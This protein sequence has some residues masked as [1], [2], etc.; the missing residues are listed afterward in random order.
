MDNVSKFRLGT[1]VVLHSFS[2]P[3]LVN[4]KIFQN[5]VYFL[6]LEYWRHI[7]KKY[8]RSNISDGLGPLLAHGLQ[9]LHGAFQQLHLV[10]VRAEVDDRWEGKEGP[11]HP[12]DDGEDKDRSTLPVHDAGI[13]ELEHAGDEGGDWGG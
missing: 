1:H 10:V 11:E 2:V 3:S 9:L 4:E 6:V 5:D 7:G 12:K 8:I 13:G